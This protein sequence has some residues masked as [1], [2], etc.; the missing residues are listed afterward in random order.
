MRYRGQRR[1]TKCAVNDE[2]MILRSS[3]NCQCANNSND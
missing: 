3:N 1:S 2:Q